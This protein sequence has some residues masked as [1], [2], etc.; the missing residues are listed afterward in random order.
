MSSRAALLGSPNHNVATRRT[1]PVLICRLHMFFC[2]SGW[3]P[4]SP[5]VC[6]LLFGNRTDHDQR[7]R[8][9]AVLFVCG[10]AL[11]L[12]GTSVAHASA[13]QCEGVPVNVHAALPPEGSSICRSAAHIV[14]RL[15]R[16]G[17]EATSPLKI[18]VVQELNANEGRA[19]GCFDRSSGTIRL[20]SQDR[21]AERLR[22]DDVRRDLDAADYF[23]SVVVHEVAH[24]ILMQHAGATSLRRIAHE[25][26][27]YALQID[28]L[29]QNTRETFLKRLRE[30]G[31]LRIALP[32]EILLMMDPSIFAAMAYLHFKSSQDQC[33][34]IWSVLRG[35]V[36]F[37]SID[38]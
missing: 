28:S 6:I 30:R 13:L 36:I 1:S 35:D 34:T 2:S 32:N 11:W 18:E 3:L 15:Q 5:G 33:A 14:R 37:P 4:P 8:F 16:C 21:C 23:Q 12:L 29:A 27:A 9:N 20:L 10:F 17:I 22:T 7:S 38:E 24:A 25:Y 19:L 31:A 26:L